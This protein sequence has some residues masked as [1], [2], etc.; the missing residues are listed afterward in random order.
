MEFANY[1]YGNAQEKLLSNGSYSFSCQHGPEECAGNLIEVCGTYYHNTT[2]EWFPFVNCVEGASLSPAE[3]AP[4]CAAQAGWTD[5][6]SN[7][8]PCSTGA[9]GNKLLHA[10]GVKTAGLS[11]PHSFTPWVVLNGKPLS[12]DEIGIPLTSLV[13][14]A[15]TGAVKPPAC[16]TFEAQGHQLCTRD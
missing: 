13:C 7:I 6:T 3:A 14:A 2:A 9:L 15:Y 10:V 4:G 1:P 8:L 5:Y 16:S 12:R 11:P